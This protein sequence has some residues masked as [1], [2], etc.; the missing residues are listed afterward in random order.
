[1][2]YNNRDYARSMGSF[3]FVDLFAGLGGFHYALQSIGGDCVFASEIDSG[4]RELYTVNHGLTKD[5]IYG[6]ISKYKCLVPSHD[7]LCAGFPC[8][9]FSK[10]GSQLGFNDQKRGALIFDVIDILSSKRPKYFIFEN[11]GNLARHNKGETWKIIRDQLEGIGYNVRST[12]AYAKYGGGQQLISPHLYGY[13]QRRERFFAIGSLD[14]LPANPFPVPT[15]ERP[16]LLKY[17]TE[18]CPEERTNPLTYQMHRAVELWNQFI[19]DLPNGHR[20]LSGAFPLW[21][22]EYDSCYPYISQTPFQYW[23]ECGY[24][25]AEVERR[26]DELPPYA[27]DQRKSFPLWK[28]KYLD[29]NREWFERF[30]HNINPQVVANIR[31]LDHTYR[32]L[33]W[34]WKDSPS[35]NI[36]DHTIQFRPSG[37]RVSNPSYVPTIVSLNGSQLPVFGPFR[38]HLSTAEVKKIFGFPDNMVLPS[39]QSAAVH[40]LGN[41]V[42]VGVA[43]LIAKCLIEYG[44][45]RSVVGNTSEDET[46]EVAA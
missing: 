40:A 28:I 45:S 17:L 24:S 12:S 26:L 18:Y 9:P 34:C 21:L 30:K 44:S 16:D 46:F 35:S 10:S 11:V 2:R 29:S 19:S 31:K 33:E 8:Q 13:P 1:M 32:K 3:K 22:E 41:A 7:V 36:W 42:H 27:R 5:R 4:L 23:T 43:R 14:Y 39:K 38:R 6:D 15:G 37:V 25:S 20:S